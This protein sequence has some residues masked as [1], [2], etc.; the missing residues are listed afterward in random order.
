MLLTVTVVAAIHAVPLAECELPVRGNEK[1]W[2]R[3][4]PE[5]WRADFED[6]QQ[7]YILCFYI[8]RLR[9]CKGAALCGES[10]WLWWN[11]YKHHDKGH[12]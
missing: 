4:I 7:G 1:T 12:L 5:T 11:M 3:E 8:L 9:H 10:Q 6:A 2:E